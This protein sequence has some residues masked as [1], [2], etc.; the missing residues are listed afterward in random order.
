MALGPDPELRERLDRKFRLKF[1]LD[2]VLAALLLPLV[3]VVT[4]ATAAIAFLEGLRDPG[5]RGPLLYREERWTRGR[6]FRILKFRTARVG[7]QAPGQVGRVT[8]TGGLLKRYYLD[9][10]P[11]VLNILRGE[12]TFVGPRPNTPDFARREIEQEGMRS[13]LLLRAGLTGL[14]QAHKGEARDRQVY[15]AF[16]DEYLEEVLRR[17]PLGVVLY[18]LELMRDTIPLVLRGEGL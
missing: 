16:E 5:S 11:Q 10:L 8:R 1:L 12:M 2:R 15:R 13:K 3:L 4:A 9:E 18:D 17:S 7:T 6:P 14:V